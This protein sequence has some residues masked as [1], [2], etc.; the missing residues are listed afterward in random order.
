MFVNTDG[1]TRYFYL[2]DSK[3]TT[4]GNLAFLGFMV[5][6]AQVEN[7][8]ELI[9][10]KGYNLGYVNKEINESE[11]IKALLKDP[12]ITEIT[13]NPEHFTRGEMAKV[14]RGFIGTAIYTMFQSDFLSHV[15]VKVL[16]ANPIEGYTH[17]TT[18]SITCSLDS[19]SLS[20]SYRVAE[21]L[22]YSRYFQNYLT[23]DEKVELLEP[24]RD[25]ITTLI[26]SKKIPEDSMEHFNRMQS[27]LISNEVELFV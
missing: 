25:L 13:I 19:N 27:Y 20:Q 4:K 18:N 2:H 24:F 12:E 15:L 17:F 1:F 26:E 3:Q 9:Q 22:G 7:L 10:N 14:K 11:D 6:P 16:L 23:Q 5:R 21:D 8:V